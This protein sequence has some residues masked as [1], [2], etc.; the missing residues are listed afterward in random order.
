MT[1]R[2]PILLLSAMLLAAC[3]KDAPTSGTT[4]EA[5]APRPVAE[6]EREIAARLAEQKGA[7]DSQ[8]ALQGRRQDRE[9]LVTPFLGLMD[10]FDEARSALSRAER[11]ETNEELIVNLEKI[12]QEAT[13]LAA[14]GCVISAR[15]TMLSAIDKTRALVDLFKDKKDAPSPELQ[16]S[17]NEAGAEQR[18]AREEFVACL[19][20]T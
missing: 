6:Q 3:G 19:E 18:R 10:R 7:L 20:V 9:R 17:V 16:K 4:A 2:I 15:T 8:S 11:K 5:N 13:Q 14:E 1:M 12:K